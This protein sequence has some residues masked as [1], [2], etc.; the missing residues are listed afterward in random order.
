MYPPPPPTYSQYGPPVMSI[1]AI[2]NET[3]R[4]FRRHSTLF[5]GLAALQVIPQL[6]L[7]VVLQATGVLGRSQVQLEA[8]IAEFTRRFEAGNSQDTSFI[9]EFP[10]GLPVNAIA[11]LLV[12]S[13]V[14]FFIQF[15]VFR[16]LAMGASVV[17][18]GDA[19]GTGE[20]SWGR[21]VQGALRHLPAL[22]S[23]AIL[24]G[25]S[26]FALMI[27]LLIPCLGIFMWFGVVL[28]LAMRL[29]LVPQ[30][31]VAEDVN[32]FTAMGRSWEL[33]R[34]SFWRMLGAWLLFVLLIGL[35]SGLITTLFSSVVA[36]VA[37]STSG[38]AIA[39][40]QGLSTVLGL[41]TI[42]LAYIGFTLLYYDHQRRATVPPPAPPQYPTYT[43]YQ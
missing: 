27:L 33:T 21:S 43:P 5:M 1:G 20:P 22:L 19:Y 16:T 8:V 26:F 17:A 3:I 40:T 37:G 7:S 28:F 34:N 9:N 24:A 31:I 41:V 29:L 25:F 30:I 6:L 13:L 12:W 38:V 10:W 32:V 18:V 42:P 14:I 39:F 35:L 23:W 15:F 2:W 36:S 11:Q 4:L